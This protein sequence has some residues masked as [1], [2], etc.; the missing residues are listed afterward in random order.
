[1]PY[2]TFL[3]TAVLSLELIAP[4]S[5]SAPPSETTLP[6]NVLLGNYIMTSSPWYQHGAC[7]QPLQEGEYGA[8]R[9]WGAVGYGICCGVAGVFT[10]RL[11]LY[12]GFAASLLMHLLTLVPSSQIPIGARKGVSRWAG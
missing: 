1:M 2:H 12:A 6:S 9:C 10:Q 5:L 4:V 3:P 7:Q 8:V 11:G